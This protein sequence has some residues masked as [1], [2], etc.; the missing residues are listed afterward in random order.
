M[1]IRCIINSYSISIS[2]SIF[3]FSTNT[4]SL[5]RRE[6]RDE[7]RGPGLAPR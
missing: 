4:T 6:G 3:F 1:G 7:I 5:Y 2:M